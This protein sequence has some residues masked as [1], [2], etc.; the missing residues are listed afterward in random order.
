MI[1]ADPIHPW[2]YG[3]GYLYPAQ[4]Y[5]L[6]RERLQPGG[7]MCQWVPAYELSLES[8]KSVVGTFAESFPYLTLWQASNDMILVGS[9]SPIHVDVGVLAQRLAEPAVARQLARV[10]LESATSFLAGFVM[11]D[12]GVE[13]WVE[14]AIVNTDD[15]LYL[16]FSSPL[17]IGAPQLRGNLRS[18]EPYRTSPLAVV[19]DVS[20]LF[21]SVAE[22]EEVFGTYQWAK[23]RVVEAQLIRGSIEQ[24]GGGVRRAA[25]LQRVNRQMRHVVRR[26]PEYAPARIELAAGLAQ[27]GT[28]Q[29]K[30]GR[31]HE[32][33]RG[34]QEAVELAPEN[35]DC[36]RVLGMAMLQ[37]GEY[38]GAVEHLETALDLRPRSWIAY[39]QLAA[40]L[41][42]VERDG[43]A[44]RV[45]QRG[46]AIKPGHAGMETLLA[47]LRAVSADE[48]AP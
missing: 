33:V 12:P 45:I 5:R 18:I 37:I 1:T 31:P 46:L 48:V 19:G 47:H 26:L 43:D 36:H 11:D 44:L 41:K 24:S 28:A 20:P 8:F 29:L 27:L 13:S 21:A 39:Y 4:Y 2:A 10:G 30:S 40:A 23:S 34:C 6:A 9:N 42:L 25:V 3:A 35:A 22:A 15:N 38:T 7:V 32:A 14:G 17:G 16:E